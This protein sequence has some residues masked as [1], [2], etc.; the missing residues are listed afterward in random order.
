MSDLPDDVRELVEH[1]LDRKDEYLQSGVGLI[2]YRSPGR[3]EDVFP[4]GSLPSE[5]PLPVR[6]PLLT[7]P[8]LSNRAEALR[9]VRLAHH[10]T[11][12]GLAILAATPL[13]EAA[14][15][16]DELERSE[17]WAL[18]SSALVA[19]SELAY[20]LERRCLARIRSGVE[21]AAYLTPIEARMAKAMTARGL[22]FEAQHRIGRYR[23]DF[24][25]RDDET[26]RLTAVEC[27]GAGFH[28]RARD[29]TRD[30]ELGRAGVQVLRFSGSR[31]YREAA[32]CAEEVEFARS[33]PPQT[34][35]TRPRHEALPEAQEAA[36]DHADGPARVA[37]P[38]GSGKTRVI[39]TRV[40]RLIDR[41]VDPTR[42]CAISFTNQAVDEMRV[43]L[44]DMAGEVTFTTLHALAKNIAE[45]SPDARA[46]RLIQGIKPGA[47]KDTPTRWGVLRGLLEPN[48]YGFRRSNELWVEA[49][50]SYRA[51]FHT[52]SF[53]DWEERFRPSV[54]RFQKICGAYD[55]QLRQRGLTDFE[56]YVLDATRA[57]ARHPTYRLQR[58]GGYDHWIVDEYQDLPTGKLRF[59]RLLVAPARNLFVV[60]DDDQVLYGFAG[61]SPGIFSTFSEEFPDAVEL[62]LDT[63]YRSPHE[64]V[65]RSTW[66]ID[67]NRERVAKDI[68]PNKPLAES[69]CVRVR[70]DSRYDDE[71]MAFISERM[72]TGRPEDIAVLFRLRD[73]AIPL[74]RQLAEQGIPF[75]SCSNAFFFASQPV[76][77]LFAWLAL[78]DPHGGS[79]QRSLEQ[80][81]RWPT[82]YLKKATI[83][84]I[85][86]DDDLT[87]ASTLADALTVVASH[88]ERASDHQRDALQRYVTTV[89]GAS[90]LA[91]PTRILETLRLRELLA[92]EAAPAGQANPVVVYDIV[93]R[94]AEQFPSTSELREWV[95]NHRH[96]VDYDFDPPET[97]ESAPGAVT[98]ASVHLAKGKEWPH[99]AVVGPLDGMPDRRAK[100]PLELEEERRI[101]YVAVTRAKSSLLFCAS[102]LYATELEARADGLTWTDY[103]AGLREPSAPS[104]QH[105]A[106]PEWPDS[107]RTS[108]RPA[109]DGSAPEGARKRRGIWVLQPEAPLTGGEHRCPC[110]A[111]L[112]KPPSDTSCPECGA[113][114]NPF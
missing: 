70:R 76:K 86:Q 99:V 6:M 31:I 85:I 45:N 74:E 88:A 27:D 82:R 78:L 55:E 77:S 1:W 100:R 47:A 7:E 43:R 54:D 96:D 102:S 110:G 37:A 107:S 93:Y 111:R 81:L 51:S 57:L 106:P 29:L 14:V 53:D 46:K 103:R 83:E 48:E 80:T 113:P 36:V 104:V 97:V 19:R 71:A 23:V 34:A 94:L 63:N 17:P 75:R 56:G 114:I 35:S 28:D 39:E 42:I 3:L 12:K 41:G 64:I 49:V 11:K 20:T 44:G 95:S 8:V 108:R 90:A 62:T 65:V 9:L 66:L 98:L 22:V 89:R 52:P 40:R 16:G 87:T 69:D 50:G 4:T 79:V 105:G 58:A 26:Q 73:M 15:A 5:A 101:A 67:R 112:W 32:S 61:A 38:A 60:G 10:A 84:A 59:L 21:G 72:Q 91:S 33:V 25:L 13:V 109:W 24:L 92:K 2:I 30:E 68:T 18:D